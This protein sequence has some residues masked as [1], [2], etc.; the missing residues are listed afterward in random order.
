MEK[1]VATQVL[2]DHEREQILVALGMT[3]I[4]P[5]AWSTESL[6]EKI[7]ESVEGMD[8]PSGI[9][10]GEDF[11]VGDGAHQGF[12]ATLEEIEGWLDG[13]PLFDSS[14]QVCSNAARKLRGVIRFRWDE[15]RRA[16]LRVLGIEHVNPRSWSTAALVEEIKDCI[17]GQGLLSGDAR[18]LAGRRVERIVELDPDDP[19]LKRAWARFPASLAES[20]GQS[21]EY[22]ATELIDRQWV[23][24]FLNGWI[25]A[26]VP[27][28]YEWGP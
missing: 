1:D 13:V 9:L 27:A 19:E 4:D 18:W 22:L 16:I 11:A 12:D 7:K 8:Q 23:H 3:K 6:V 25:S 2:W 15:E 26:R 5:R 24:I 20:H 21:W 28:R 10:M 14:T 17:D